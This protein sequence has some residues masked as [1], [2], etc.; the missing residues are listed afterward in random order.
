MDEVI[1]HLGLL[2]WNFLVD[3]VGQNHPQ[4]ALD[5]HGKWTSLEEACGAVEKGGQNLTHGETSLFALIESL[6]GFNEVDGGTEGLPQSHGNVSWQTVKAFV[7]VETN[8]MQ[9][10][11]VK[12]SLL[13]F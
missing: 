2:R 13:K 3:V 12:H 5:V 11:V 6:D 1:G 4:R 9:W 7:P 8:S 10:L